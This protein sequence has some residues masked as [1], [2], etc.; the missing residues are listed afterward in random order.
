MEATAINTKPKKVRVYTDYD[1]AYQ[2]SDRGKEVRKKFEDN[3]PEYRV[4]RDRR[5]H[6]LIIT[7]YQEMLDNIKEGTDLYKK[8]QDKIIKFKKL[9]DEDEEKINELS[10]RL[11]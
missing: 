3:H 6:L 5:R 8:Y 4:R 9:V 7:K 1:R 2:K 11:K 10:D